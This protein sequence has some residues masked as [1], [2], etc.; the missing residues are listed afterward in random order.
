MNTAKK[1]VKGAIQP[2]QIKA[3]H[4][5]ATKSGLDD[6]AYRGLLL[7]RY[8]ATSCKQLSWRQAEEL[9]DHLNGKAGSSPDKGR[10]GRGLPYSDM[11]GRP[12]FATGAQCRLL[13]AMFA[14]VSKVPAE[15]LAGR[16]KALNVFCARIL[17][18][19]GLRMVRSYQVEKI[20]KALEAMGA[21]KKEA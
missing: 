16:E 2:R 21:V 6:D 5:A 19:A 9:L 11:D 20:V 17:N 7:F 8:N 1:F 15:D 18:V 12:G 14:Q 10:L 13:A 4:A 3:I